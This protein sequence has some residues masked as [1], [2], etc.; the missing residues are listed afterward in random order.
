MPAQEIE[1]FLGLHPLGDN[2]EAQAMRQ[3]NNSAGN[4][5]IIRIGGDVAHE[6]LID[7][8]GIDG[9]ALKI[10]QRRVAGAEVVHGY[11]DATLF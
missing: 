2:G 4:G 7:L 1:L 5:C 6:R 3:V 10:T 9:E 8:Q 11:F